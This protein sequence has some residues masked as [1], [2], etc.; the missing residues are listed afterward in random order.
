MDDLVRSSPS[1]YV[2]AAQHP[3]SFENPMSLD[4]V[5]GQPTPAVVLQRQ[6]PS[7]TVVAPDGCVMVH[8]TGS[9]AATA[10]VKRSLSVFGPEVKRH[11]I[12]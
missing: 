8:V 12:V 7:M 6:V 4:G 9:P 10:V 1:T 5:C 11:V 2:P 3:S